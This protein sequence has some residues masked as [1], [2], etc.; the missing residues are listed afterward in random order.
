MSSPTF[1]PFVKKGRDEIMEITKNVTIFLV[2][3]FSQKH[4]KNLG[5]TSFFM[6]KKNKEQEVIEMTINNILG[7]EYNPSHSGFLLTSKVDLIVK[8]N[9]HHA[10][11]E[12]KNFAVREISNWLAMICRW[13]RIYPFLIV[14]DPLPVRFLLFQF[15]KFQK[16]GLFLFRR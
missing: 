2:T 8:K 14:T 16:I 13:K 10:G 7:V 5:I 1:T 6:K 11:N 3:R 15:H 12:S 9:N 4:R